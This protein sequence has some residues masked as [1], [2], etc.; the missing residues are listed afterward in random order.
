M[1]SFYF[2]ILSRFLF[3]SLLFNLFHFNL[4]YFI[5]FYFILILIL[6]ISHFIPSLIFL[7]FIQIDYFR[8]KCCPLF[9]GSKG[10]VLHVLT[11]LFAIIDKRFNTN[12][13][14]LTLD[15]SNLFIHFI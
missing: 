1:I 10:Y 3:F 4:F 2:F 12:H 9:M 8:I 14:V 11:I 15:D 6:I 7:F 13:V 5:L